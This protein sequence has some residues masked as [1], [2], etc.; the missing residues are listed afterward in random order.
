MAT[1]QEKVA[2]EVK[3]RV[4]DLVD[5]STELT[6]TAHDKAEMALEQAE[7]IIMDNRRSILTIGALIGIVIVAGIVARLILGARHN[8]HTK[9]Q[10]SR[11]ATANRAAK[12]N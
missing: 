7:Q 8:R 2:K 3:S 12:K 9:P 11:K 4:E 6:H 1:K 10:V 5:A